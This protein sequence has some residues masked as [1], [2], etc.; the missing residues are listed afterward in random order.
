MKAL[1]VPSGRV[2]APFGD[3]VSAARV[4]DLPL[5]E[6]QER[7]LTQAGLTLVHAPPVGEPFLVFSDR[8]WFS[9]RLL[10]LLVQAGP[11]RLRVSHPEYAEA[12][13]ALQDLPAPGLYEIGIVPAGQSAA[14][15]R[16]PDLAPVD[17]DLGLKTEALQGIHPALAFA[18]KPIPISDA[19]VHQVDHWTHLL[20]V[21]L[22]AMAARGLEAKRSWDEA[23]GWKKALLALGFLLKVRPTSKAAVLRGLNVVGKGVQIHPTATVELCT[24]EDGVEI[25]PCAVVRGSHIGKGAKIE[26]HTSVNLSVLGAGAK[27]SR[28]GMLNMSVVYPGAQVSHADGFQATLIGQDAFAGWGIAALDISFGRTVRVERDGEWVDSGQHF[29]GACIGHRAKVTYGAILNYGV[30]VP[31]DA[32]LIGPQQSVLR[33]WGDAPVGEPLLAEGGVPVPAKRRK[34]GA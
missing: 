3:P 4:L 13:E 24:L 21:N 6:A 23:P 18:S 16:F 1:R 27:L 20:R 28:F 34:A 17:V 8:T 25:G 31:N 10:R 19:L 7:A 29:L 9:A 15:D 11:G 12:Y 22:L 5:R 30:T 26:E 32:F 14:L 2:L 33:R